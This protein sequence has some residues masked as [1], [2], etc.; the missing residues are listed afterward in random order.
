MSLMFLILIILAQLKNLGAKHWLI[1]E[2]LFLLLSLDVT[3]EAG[4]DNY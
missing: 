3:L 1:S 2:T 4:K